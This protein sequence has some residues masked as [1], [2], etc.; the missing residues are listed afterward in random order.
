M[1]KEQNKQQ[2]IPVKKGK[3]KPPRPSSSQSKIIPK[4]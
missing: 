2:I 3:T 1:A 4:K